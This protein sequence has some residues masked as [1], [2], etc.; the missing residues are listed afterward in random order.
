MRRAGLVLCCVLSSASLATPAALAT[1]VRQDPAEFEH[2]SFVEIETLTP[3]QVESL[4][5]LGKVW[6][7]VKYHHP[8]VAAGEL[9][10]D[11]EL[12]RVL[13]AV[14]DAPERAACAQALVAWLDE[15]GAPAPCAPCAEAPIDAH[16]APELDWLADEAR[17]GAELAARLARIHRDRFAGTA[18]HYVAFV[19]QIGNP[20]FAREKA[21]AQFA[22]PDAGYRLLALF[23]F[24]NVIAWWFPYRD[25]IG[26]DWDAVLAEFVP[27]FATARGAEAYQRELLALIARAHDTHANLWSSLEARPPTGAALL[28]VLVRFI[29]GRALVTGTTDPARPPAALRVG[30][31]LLALDGEPVERLVER[32]APYYAASNEPTRRRDLARELTRGAPGPVALRVERDGAELELTEERRPVA[33][34]GPERGATHDLAGPT[35]RLLAPEVGYLKLSTIQREDIAAH[36]AAAAGTRGLVLDLRNYPSAFVVFALGQ[37]LVREPTPFVRFTQGTAANPGAFLWGVTLSVTPHAPHYDGRVVILVD[38]VTQSQAEYTAM[39]FRVAPGALV[40][41]STTAGADGNVSSLVLPGGL[42]TMISGIG[43]FYPD[44]RPT[45]RVGI[46]PDIEVLPTVAGLRA[47]RDEVLEAGLR[48]ILGPGSEAEAERI[49]RAALASAR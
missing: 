21:Y 2:G 11:A 17:L 10:F 31:V 43:I 22:E 15:L 33:E 12:L 47:G 4:V 25:V 35:F 7:F 9:D 13:P 34:L 45:Q 5:T 14:L 27:R 18:Q 8:R 38:E 32:W 36:L 39:A 37:H 48:A 20:D 24:W 44:G 1:P 30:D 16:L 3:A 28:P 42:G 29:E 46:V 49:A 23:R 19:P 41:G 6:G 40:V 26:A